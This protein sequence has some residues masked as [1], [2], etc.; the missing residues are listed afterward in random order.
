MEKDQNI[1]S[2][3]QNEEIKET[4]VEEQIQEKQE[5]LA[6]KKEEI[7]EVT[8]EEKIKEFSSNVFPFSGGLFILKSFGEHISTFLG[9]KSL[10]S[11]NF[12][13]LLV[14]TNNFIILFFN[15]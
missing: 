14:P 7:K 5:I 9:N 12:P 15:I 1:N 2:E 13:L 4:K 8:P 11:F 3:S 6:E 10:I